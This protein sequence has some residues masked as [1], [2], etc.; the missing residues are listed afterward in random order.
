MQGLPCGMVGA[1]AKHLPL[2][3]RLFREAFYKMLCKHAE[4]KHPPNLQPLLYLYSL[5]ENNHLL[6]PFFSSIDKIEGRPSGLNFGQEKLAHFLGCSS[7][8]GMH[9]H[10][11][12]HLPKTAL[13]ALRVNLL[14]LRW[15]LAGF[16][17]LHGLEALHPGRCTPGRGGCTAQQRRRISLPSTS[18]CLAL[19]HTLLHT[20][21][22]QSQSL[23]SSYYYKKDLQA[24]AGFLPLSLIRL[25]HTIL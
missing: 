19:P 13:L 18:M 4:Q 25:L 6:E 14:E 16:L 15:R 17:E 12:P 9:H 23:S 20:S 7:R 3:Q 10:H 1:A 24:P 2:T 11:Y 5:C 22:L 8:G 21:H